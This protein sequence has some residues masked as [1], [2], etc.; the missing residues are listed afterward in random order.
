MVIMAEDEAETEESLGDKEMKNEIPIQ[1]DLGEAIKESDV[2]KEED[3]GGTTA[4]SSKIQIEAEDPASEN[5][6]DTDG[7]EKTTVDAATASE[8]HDQL[9]CIQ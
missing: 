7:E 4:L 3:G 9:S 6:N 8:R 1:G 5:E 2:V